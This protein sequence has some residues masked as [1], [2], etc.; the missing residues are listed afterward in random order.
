MA[1]AANGNGTAAADLTGTAAALT[2]AKVDAAML[3]AY[4]DGG[5]PNLLL[6]SPTNKQNFSGLSSGSVAT[7]QITT[8][9]PKEASIVG[10]VKLAA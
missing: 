4:N 5:A 1:A 9:A 6:M 3:A 8:S 7:N 10:S 2:L